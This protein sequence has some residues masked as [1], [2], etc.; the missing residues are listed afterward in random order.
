MPLR[1]QKH[2]HLQPSGTVTCLQLTAALS[3]AGGIVAVINGEMNGPAVNVFGD[4]VAVT[5]ASAPCVS[6]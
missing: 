3:A 4:G 1:G 6:I 2:V 5:V